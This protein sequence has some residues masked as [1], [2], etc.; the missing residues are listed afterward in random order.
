MKIALAQVNPTVGDFAGN[1]AK[2]RDFARQAQARGADLVVFTELCICGYP[3][4]DLAENP[5]FRQRNRQELERLARELPLPAIVGFVGQAKAPT[6]K[7]ATNR[8]AL[9]AQG[10]VLFEQDKMLLPTYDVFDEARHFAP[11]ESQHLFT[12][13]GLQLALTIC[14]DA[15]NDRHFWER[16]LY[17]R[18]PVEELMRQG[19]NLLINISASPFH[20][21]KRPH[22]LAM[23]QALARRYQAPVV[24]VNQAGGNDSLIFD[25]SSVAITPDGRVAARAASFAEDLV[26]FDTV[27][28]QGDIR[29]QPGD[30]TEALWQAL[31]LGIRDYVR[32]CGF[33]KVVVGLSGGI[34]SSLVAI[35]AV[36]AL[37]PENVLGV[38][39]PGPYSS[40]ASLT[41]A[42]QLARNLGIRFQVIS[43]TEVFE[44]YKKM[45]AEAFQGYAEDETEENLQ[46]RIRGNTLMALS[47]KFGA[48][49]LSTGN[50]SEL[51]VGYCTL[52]GDLA[53]GLAVI[54]DVPKMM[55]YAL[56]R[57]ANRERQ[58]IPAAC[59][60][61]PPSAELRADQTDQDTLPPY[62]VLD[63]I[64]EAY[65][66]ELKTSAQIATDYHIDLAVVQDVVRRVHRS[67]YKRY[68]APPGLKV[69]PKAFGLGR[70]LPIAQR[71]AE[72]K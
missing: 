45:L 15:W 10:R 22:H 11:A 38:G 72:G 25:G 21:D 40:P 31:V 36:A 29:P 44:Q 20:K 43:I 23:L 2:L 64:L 24:M 26:L 37:G 48:L 18:D 47:N 62:P 14:E 13:C 17:P 41:D 66:E 16:P 68:Q 67:E 9:V 1:T 35:L 34:D 49:V 71:Y 27:T 28:G 39:M 59:F 7:Q 42:Q 8:A 50:K 57:L 4:H 19:S 52:Y 56:A 3:P 51:A 69:T 53:G 32:K 6:G 46:A 12:F 58:F 5:S 65:I 61:K 60:A 33:E 55:V 30:E 63:Q 54:S 70:R